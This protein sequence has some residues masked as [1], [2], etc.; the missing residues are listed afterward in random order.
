MK[1]KLVAILALCLSACAALAE[2]VNPDVAFPGFDMKNMLDEVQVNG[3]NVYVLNAVGD[4]WLVASGLTARRQEV[5]Q[6][7]TAGEILSAL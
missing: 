3:S 6:D 4:A 1:T 2:P 7:S 5:L